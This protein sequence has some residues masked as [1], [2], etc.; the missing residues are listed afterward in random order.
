[1]RV[2]LISLYY[3]PDVAS[4]G[5][6]MARIME[7]LVEQ[8]H[9]VSVVTSFPHY[10]TYRTASNYRSKMWQRERQN[11]VTVMRVP[12]YAPGQKTTLN[13]LINYFSFSTLCWLAGTTLGRFDIILVTS[14]PLT[15][16]LSGHL[17]TLQKRGLMVYALQDIWP[18]VAFRVGALQDGI[19]LRFFEQMERFIYAKSAHVI[20]LTP[21][22]RRNLRF[23]FFELS[24]RFFYYIIMALQ[25]IGIQSKMSTVWRFTKLD[26]FFRSAIPWIWRHGP[27]VALMGIK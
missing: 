3:A 2:L 9:E 21:G 18:D 24:W 15:L 16:G 4:T 6:F 13:R 1:M 23:C 26:D 10:A 12:V 25:R 8:G 20:A 22:F 7:D 5:V 19:T 14:P 17:L 27:Q 11:G